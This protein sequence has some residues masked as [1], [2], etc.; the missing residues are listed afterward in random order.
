MFVRI[1]IRSVPS[2]VTVTTDLG[3]ILLAGVEFPTL[4]VNS[5][6]KFIIYK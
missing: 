3:D 4:T 1:L 2:S 5:N 6:T